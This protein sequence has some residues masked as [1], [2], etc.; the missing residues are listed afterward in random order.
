M[1]RKPWKYIGIK[2]YSE[3]VA[4]DD[5]FLIF[6]RFGTLNT[7]LALALQDEIS[8]FE[9][10]LLDLDKGYSD[11]NGKDMNNGS[12]RDDM[13]DRAELLERIREKMQR[14][15]TT[16]PQELPFPLATLKHRLSHTI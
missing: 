12:F 11:K 2:G 14:Y 6:R 3:F 1:R 13:D 16:C 10:Q 9:Q 15:S 4:S 7:R 8:V 5:D